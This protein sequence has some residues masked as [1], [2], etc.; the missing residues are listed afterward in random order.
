MLS[1]TTNSGD[2]LLDRVDD[3]AQ[4]GLGGD[5]DAGRRAAET[6]GATLHL[7]GA[8]LGAHVQRRSGP[9]G[10]QLQYQ[11][12]LADPRL[13][14]EQRDRP[15]DEPAAEH[16]I[17]LVDPRRPG[18]AGAGVD[19]AEAH[20]RGELGPLAHPILRRLD[21]LLDNRVPG[22][23]ARALPGPLGMGG[24]ALDAGE[25]RRRLRHEGNDDRWVSVVRAMLTTSAPRSARHRP[26]TSKGHDITANTSRLGSSGSAA[27]GG[28][29][30]TRLGRQ[31]GGR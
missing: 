9:P 12:A 22:R 5:P 30:D 27:A 29:G 6:I 7:L 10:E 20:G 4:R 11:R 8:L 15:G 31:G 23:A 18:L 19:V 28:R 26:P 24:P 13:P 16:S 17:E 21:R 3:A 25:H 1:T 2:V 14:A